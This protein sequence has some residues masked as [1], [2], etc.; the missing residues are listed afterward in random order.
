MIT[1]SSNIHLLT[2]GLLLSMVLLVA[3]APGCKKN[4]PP[5]PQATPLPSN[6]QPAAPGAP[7]NAVQAK[8]STVQ[9]NAMAM[10]L[11]KQISTATRLQ[12]PGAVSLDFSTRRDP[13]KPFA[14]V[15]AAQKTVVAKAGRVKDPLPIQAFDTE[16][17]RVTGIITGL[18]ANSALIIDPNGKGYV[19]K[20]G[21]LIGNNDGRV[22]R[23]TNSVVEVEESFSDDSGRV[24]KRL[25]KLTL[26]R[27]K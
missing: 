8:V 12:P 7:A 4:E 20:E 25:V 11:Q 21:M 10:P 17:F 6:A 18:K 9:K 1:R 13:F 19:V 14:Q 16:K 23:V 26:L 15:P 3:A 5:P 27:K 24:R 22:K 2:R